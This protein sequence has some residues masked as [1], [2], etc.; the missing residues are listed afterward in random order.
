MNPEQKGKFIVLYGPNNLGKTSQAKMLA[1][2]LEEQGIKTMTIKYPVYDLKP[3]GHKLNAVLREGLQMPEIEVQKL[4]AQNR[5]DFEPTLRNHLT[6]GAWVV[7]EDYTGTGI[8]W[9][10][11]RGVSLEALE[12]M[13]KGL[14]QE[15][16]AILLHGERFLNNIEEGH[17][18][19]VDDEIWSRAQEMHLFL[20]KRYGWR[21]VYATRSKEAVHQDILAIICE[22]Y[23]L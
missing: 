9:G 15:D 21:K 23:K 6:S 19:E 5:R 12:A 11:V 3:T 16:L 13:N 14:R 22:Q 17:R 2:T 18:N 10:L 1:E 20:A 8:A 4:Y 7:A